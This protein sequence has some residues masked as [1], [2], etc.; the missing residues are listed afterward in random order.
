[1]D[2]RKNIFLSVL[3]LLFS[4][5]I[6]SQAEKYPV[7]S[8]CESEQIENLPT[9]FKNEVK[10]AII[11]EFEIPETILQQNFKGLINVVFIV[12]A[13]G[14]FKVLYVN[15]PYKELKTEVERVFKTLPKITP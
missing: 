1:M 12:D 8:A 14:N 11:S 6:F 13:T 9:C 2:T 15:S 4:V 5:V 3:F 7:F 10:D